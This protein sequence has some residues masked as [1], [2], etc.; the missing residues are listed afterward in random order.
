MSPG[1][2]E[3][4]GMGNY[5]QKENSDILHGDPDILRSG[6]DILRSGNDIL[7]GG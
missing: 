3:Y 6:H 4:H 7:S 1:S 5:R 2:Q